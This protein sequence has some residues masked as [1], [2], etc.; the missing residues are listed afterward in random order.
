MTGPTRESVVTLRDVT[1][2]TVRDICRLK[3][4]P[5]QERFV[6]PNAVSIAQAHFHKEA[7]FR[8]IAADDTLVGFVMLEDWTRFPEERAAHLYRDEQYVGLWRFMI[9]GRWQ[10]LGFGRQALQLTIDHVRANCG[11][12]Q[13]LLSYVPGGGSPDPLYRSFGFEP[14]GDMDEDEIIMRLAL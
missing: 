4:T 10:G 5:Y 13:M 14:T 1:A 8:A 7:W 11:V 2:D 6:A 9:D 3:P 12:P